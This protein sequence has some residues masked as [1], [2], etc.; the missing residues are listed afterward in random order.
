MLEPDDVLVVGSLR[1]GGVESGPARAGIKPFVDFGMAIGERNHAA[2]IMVSARPIIESS[3]RS[4][5][6]HS[7]GRD[8]KRALVQVKN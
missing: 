8:V 3:G 6:V 1:G 5:H 2:E 4:L 7:E